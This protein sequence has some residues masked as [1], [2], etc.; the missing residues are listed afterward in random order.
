MASSTQVTDHTPAGTLEARVTPT[1]N[2]PSGARPVW[3]S[4]LIGAAA[5]FLGFGLL[6]A[7]WIFARP[8]AL[9]ILGVTIAAALAPMVHWVAKA[10]PRVV[11]IVL[12]YVVLF[13]LIG[14][15]IWVMLPSFSGEALGFTQRIPQL[16][17][18]A[19]QWLNERLP[20]DVST[21]IGSL[22]SAMGNIVSN[23]AN[24]P[25]QFSS[26]LL[27]TLLVIFLSIYALVAAP[28][29]RGFVVSLFPEERRNRVEDV[30]LRMGTAMGGYVRGVF[31]S[32]VIVAIL[33]YVGLLIIG[34]QFPL[35]L[36]VISGV[37]EIVPVFGPII[38]G[39]L[40]VA[41]ALFQST[42]TALIALVFVVI[43][44]Q[45]ESNILFPL[46]LGRETDTS[47]FLN[48]FAFFAGSAVGGL[49]GALAAVPLAAALRV[50]V[51]RV[52][53]PAVR[54]WFGVTSATA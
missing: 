20:F 26:A 45:I 34:V 50:L 10:M 53:A 21:L 39:V 15:L 46:I 51:L 16:I 12:V 8:L 40:I 28:K 22:Q 18:Q 38:A 37:L 54:H 31:M 7:I 49:L 44:Q 9:L 19:Q 3:Q 29:F 14:G 11:A 33:T 27:D 2:Q 24:V 25:L 32:G 35:V 13:A 6:G 41:V 17:D 4:V 23:L 43:L 42:T 1:Q 30:M 36:G 48:L 47:P 5:L 52:V